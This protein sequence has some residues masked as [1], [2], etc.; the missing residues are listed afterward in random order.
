MARFSRPVLVALGTLGLL[1]GALY[2]ATWLVGP[3]AHAQNSTVRTNVERIGMALDAYR[4]TTG[5]RC[6]EPHDWVEALVRNRLLPE[7]HLPPTPWDRQVQSTSLTIARDDKHLVPAAAIGR[8]ASPVSAG[9]SLGAGRAP[10]EGR[11]DDRTFGAVLYDHDPASGVYVIYGIGR[12]T[13]QE[14]VV[15]HMVTGRSR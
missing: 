4:E 9:T 10:R 11:F 5:G 2:G 7:G 6:P 13:A 14:A 8:G 3:Q 12:R 1:G 15:A